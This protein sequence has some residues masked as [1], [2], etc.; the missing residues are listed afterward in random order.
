M[1]FPHPPRLTPPRPPSIADIINAPLKVA[2]R[3]IARLETDMNQIAMDIEAFGQPLAGVTLVKPPPL[4]ESL[5]LEPPLAVPKAPAAPR[6]PAK[7]TACLAC[8]ADHLSTLTAS[9]NEAMRFARDGGIDQ[10]E[11]Q[12]RLL[13]ATDELNICERIDLA[14]DATAAL[15]PKE[16]E[17]AKWVLPQLRKLRHSLKEVNSPEDLEQVAAVALE[18]RQAYTARYKQAKGE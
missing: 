9:L 15:G 11:V 8:T 13:L 18:T 1:D 5:V 4:P 6:T 14:P 3:G 16:R 7:G 10:D 2:A 12:R 17:V